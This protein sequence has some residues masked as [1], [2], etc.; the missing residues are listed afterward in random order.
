[1]AKLFDKQ[2]GCVR[3]NRLIDRDHHIKVEKLLDQIGTFFAHPFGKL[4]NGN[5]LWHDHIAHLF[6]ARFGRAA[7]RTALFLTC[8]L[9]RSK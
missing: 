7:L 1:M 4:T 5:R 9:Q 3:I 2:F 6:L 8:A